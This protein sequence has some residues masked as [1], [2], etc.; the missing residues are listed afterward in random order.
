MEESERKNNCVFQHI[1]RVYTFIHRWSKSI[2]KSVYS[3]SLCTLNIHVHTRIYTRS[4]AK[5]IERELWAK[6]AY[7]GDETNV[8][9]ERERERERKRGCV[10]IVANHTLPLCSRWV[11]DSVRRFYASRQH[12]SVSFSREITSSIHFL[13]KKLPK[14]FPPLIPQSAVIDKRQLEKKRNKKHRASSSAEKK[15][16]EYRIV[17]G[18]STAATQRKRPKQ[19]G[20]RKS[21][22]II[23]SEYRLRK[24]PSNI[25]T[26]THTHSTDR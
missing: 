4:I 2:Y 21:S 9:S 10:P 20:K 12:P 8:R 26:R 19:K 18:V 25:H 23:V 13:K 6:R 11:A 17:D 24:P 22:W 7:V 5:T 14:N 3:L 15:C 1:E 16:Q